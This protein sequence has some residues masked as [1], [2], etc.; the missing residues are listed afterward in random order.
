[1]NLEVKDIAA[2][3]GP[4]LQ[5][6]KR[7]IAFAFILVVLI[8][9]GYLVFYIN[10]LAAKEPDEDAVT[11]RLKTVQ[12]PRIDEESL[13]KILQLEG[14]NIQ[15]QTLFQEARDNPFTE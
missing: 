15:V 11:E 4:A 6:L 12:R 7:Y 13:Q 9:Y 1:M 5:G 3:L 8:V 14:Q 10:T 2:K